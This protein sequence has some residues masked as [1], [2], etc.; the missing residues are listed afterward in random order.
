MGVTFARTPVPW[1]GIGD[2]GKVGEGLHHGDGREIQ[3]VPG[4]GVETPDP[5]LAE[6]DVGIPLG[7]DVFRGQEEFLDG[8][9]Q[10][11]FEENGFPDLPDL[12]EERIVLH[13]PGADLEDVGILGHVIRRLHIQGLGH[14]GHPGL[15]PGFCQIARAL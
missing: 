6:D 2:D 9:G 14:D 3:E 11:P 13:V 1:L 4:L 10:T 12:P 15:V 7:D 8:R 5:P